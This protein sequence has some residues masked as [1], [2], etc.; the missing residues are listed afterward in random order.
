MLA[1]GVCASASAGSTPRWLEIRSPHFIVVCDGSAR[2]AE[3]VANHFEQIRRVFHD[4]F[5]TARMDPAEPVLIFAVRNGS[6]LK[7]LV[8]SYWNRRGHMHPAGVFLSA[9]DRNYV[10]LRMDDN[11]D[12]DNQVVY[13]EYMHVLERLNFGSLPL[14]LSEGL[15]DFY[16]SVRIAGKQVGAG[17]PIEGHLDVLRSGRWLPLKKLLSAGYS[18]RY[19]NN[20]DLA[21][22]FY[23]ES[24]ELTHYLLVGEGGA[25]HGALMEYERLVENGTSSVAAARRE[26]GDLGRLEIRLKIYARKT[27]FPYYRMKAP[28]EGKKRDFPETK[29]TPAQADAAQGDFYVTSGEPAAAKAMLDEAVRLDPELAAAWVSLGRLLLG[30]PDSRAAIA[31]LDRAIALDPKNSKAYYFRAL[32]AIH[33]R[34][35]GPEMAGVEKDLQKSI[36]L[37]FNFA[38]GYRLLAEIYAAGGK[39]LGAAMALAR[40]AVNLGPGSPENYL[41]VA[42][43]LAAQ[44]KTVLSY[45]EG[46]RALSLAA[47]PEQ[48]K[49]VEDFLKQFPASKK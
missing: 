43:V 33:G 21:T 30:A 6:D 45:A 47:T 16:G 5:P 10:A 35:S 36:A 9:P 38:A 22:V 11:K 19:Y 1:A 46:Q 34:L 13:H 42:I 12:S 18:S 8:P 28:F 40:R 48:R 44:G 3:N 2:Q 27:I 29:L 15:A 26:F 39:K 32:A 37:N 41:S 20:G 25:H 14:W 17:Y 4:A 24:W 7:K 31:P 23:A 49:E